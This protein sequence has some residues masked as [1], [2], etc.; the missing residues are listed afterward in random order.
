M[1]HSAITAICVMMLAA[2]PVLAQRGGGHAS[3][4]HGGFSGHAGGGGGHYSGMRSSSGMMSH[5]VAGSRRSFSGQ[6]FA[7]TQSFARRGNST[8]RRGLQ[9]RSFNSRNCFGCRRF[10]YPWGYAGFYDPNWWWDSGSSY[11]QDYER[12]RAVAD[13]MNQDNLQEQQMRQQGDQDIYSRVPTRQSDSAQAAPAEV[14]PP[15]VLVFHDQRKQEVQNYAIVGQTLWNFSGQRTQKI[16]LSDLDLIAT[17]EA[18][19]ARGVEFRL[20]NTSEGQ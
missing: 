14:I 3:G 16:P 1:R 15:T 18:N 7:H 13:Q 2:M 6:P 10:G 20:P 17:A 19:E 11:D 4:G 5:G 9:I 12:N 8:N